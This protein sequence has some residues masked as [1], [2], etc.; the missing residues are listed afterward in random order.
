[1]KGRWSNHLQK[2]VYDCSRVFLPEEQSYRRETFSFNGKLERTQRPTILTPTQWIR[3]YEI[4]KEKE[5]T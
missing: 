5:I 3:E 1:L 2:L 4:E